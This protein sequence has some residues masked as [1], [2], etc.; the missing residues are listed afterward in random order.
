M[1]KALPMLL[2]ISLIA[3]AFAT[4]GLADLYRY[5]DRDG[6]VCMTNSLEKVPQRYRSSVKVIREERKPDQA[7][8]ELPAEPVSPPEAVTVLPTSHSVA[9]A[10]LAARFESAA[11]R[12]PWL[13]PL[14][15]LAAILLLFALITKV[16]VLLP[17]RLL[18]KAIYFAFGAGVIFFLYKSYAAHL[19]ESTEKLKQEATAAAKKAAER[20]DPLSQLEKSTR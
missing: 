17:S 4:E 1:R 14:A 2:L 8:K 12:L 5:T 3:S 19:V 18:G 10:N 20:Q 13:K 11:Q 7:R 16:T 6:V 9:P 15:C